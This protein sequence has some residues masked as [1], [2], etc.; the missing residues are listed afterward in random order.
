MTNLQHSDHD[1]RHRHN[2]DHDYQHEQEEEEDRE[3][4]LQAIILRRGRLCG[5]S[6][7]Q[8]LGAIVSESEI[9]RAA[10]NN[11]GHRSSHS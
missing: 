1:E 10:T 2:G 7:H 8:Q 6:P 3:A 11:R 9:R 4:A 5:E